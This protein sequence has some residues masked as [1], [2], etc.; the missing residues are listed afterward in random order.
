[1]S[2]RLDSR[3]PPR[4]P[5]VAARPMRVLVASDRPADLSRVRDAIRGVPEPG[6]VCEESALARLLPRVLRADPDVVLLACGRADGALQAIERLAT[7]APRYPVVLLADRD[8]EPATIPA[9]RA[10]AEDVVLADALEP[11]A[12]AR[13]LRCAIERHRHVNALREQSWTDPLTGL[14]NRRGFAALAESHLRLARR[15]DRAMLVVCADLDGLKGINDR[16]GHDEGDRALQ[17]AAVLLHQCLRE[18]D[19]VARFGGDEFVA[20]AHDA[21]L[22]SLEALRGRI[23]ARFAAD[24]AA[25]PYR[26]SLSLGAAALDASCG[27]LIELLAQADEALYRAKRRRRSPAVEAGVE[28]AAV[29]GAPPALV[30]S[31][32]S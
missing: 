20:L 9:V 18:S 13:T 25:R 14:Y 4:A 3:R 6:A 16:F 17:R 15:N 23:D 27:S 12:L 5:D 30:R 8:G 22:A 21:D 29:A 1:M 24:A 31:P 26:L 19:V 32:L 7:V 2:Q 28:G 10:G 11:A